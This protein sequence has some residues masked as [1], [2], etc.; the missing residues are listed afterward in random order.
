MYAAFDT[1]AAFADTCTS[2]TF[3]RVVEVAT[4]CKAHD[5]LDAAVSK[6]SDRIRRRDIA[7]VPA[8]LAADEHKLVGLR[9]IAYYVHLQEII[10]KSA[11]TTPADALLLFS[12]GLSE[13]Q[14]IRLLLGH[15]SLVSFWERRRRDP[16]KLEC[17]DGC[18]TAAHRTCDRV[19]NEQ[20]QVMVG[21]Q[22]VLRHNSADILAILQCMRDQLGIDQGVAQGVALACRTTGLDALRQELCDVRVALP[23]HFG[24]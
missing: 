14:R 2:A 15:L 4:R 7:A 23:E 18:S 13:K 21:S 8:I 22:A 20:W 6:W 5:L 17:A 11:P 3:T 12:T 24:C 1:D 10:E 9:G 19:W 16:P